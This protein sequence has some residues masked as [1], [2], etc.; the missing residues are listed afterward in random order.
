[1]HEKLTWNDVFQKVL[2]EKEGSYTTEHG[3]LNV[4]DDQIN[5]T[6]G[7]S[8]TGRIFFARDSV[9]ASDPSS[10]DI[11]SYRYDDLVT[12]DRLMFLLGSQAASALRDFVGG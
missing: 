7:G 6:D 2:R 12:Q 3:T 9:V 4:L 10:S 5:L 1:M 11:S 8:I